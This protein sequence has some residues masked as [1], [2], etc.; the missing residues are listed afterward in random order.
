MLKPQIL[1]TQSQAMLDWGKHPPPLT[2][3]EG[4][5]ENLKT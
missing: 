4:A 2:E 1:P 3:A 5:P